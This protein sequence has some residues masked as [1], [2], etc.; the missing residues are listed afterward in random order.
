M[1][2]PTANAKEISEFAEMQRMM[3]KPT[4]EPPYERLPADGQ[5]VRLWAESDTIKRPAIQEDFWPEELQA[6]HNERLRN[7]RPLR[8]SPLLILIATR[9]DPRPQDLRPEQIA[10]FD[11]IQREKRIQKEKLVQLS[12]NSIAVG[13]PQSG[14]H[15]QLDDPEWLT[16]ML[17][18]ELDA[19]RQHRKLERLKTNDLSVA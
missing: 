9:D 11:E 17:K 6:M 2:L 3:G 7:P 4:I 15:I 13:D 8:N 12:S 16:K 19:V 18:G 10:Q 14:H 5:R 1:K